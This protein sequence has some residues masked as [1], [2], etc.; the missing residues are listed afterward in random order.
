MQAFIT[1]AAGW[2]D[3]RLAGNVFAISRLFANQENFS[4]RR[5]LAKR[6]LG[7]I[8]IEVAT[9]TSRRLSV[10]RRPAP[11]FRV[12]FNNGWR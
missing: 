6:R 10:K 9:F 12:R 1:Q 3:E 2:G 8:L 5:S 4:P 7:G 11:R